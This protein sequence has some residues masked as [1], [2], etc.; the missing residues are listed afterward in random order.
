MFLFKTTIRE[1]SRH[2][3]RKAMPQG[4]RLFR[5]I[6]PPLPLHARLSTVGFDNSFPIIIAAA[7]L[8][9]TWKV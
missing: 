4:V 6:S 1:A 2:S 5:E 8:Y 7:E 9:P 3:T